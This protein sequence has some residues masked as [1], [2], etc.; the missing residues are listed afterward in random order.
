MSAR[1]ERLYH[2]S[3]INDIPTNVAPL[4]FVNRSELP[5]DQSK[6][7]K[8]ACYHGNMRLDQSKDWILTFWMT[9]FAYVSCLL[10]WLSSSAQ[11]LYEMWS[12]DYSS[13]GMLIAALHDNRYR[14]IIRCRCMIKNNWTIGRIIKTLIKFVMF[15]LVAWLVWRPLDPP[16]YMKLS[17]TV[18]MLVC[19]SLNGKTCQYSNNKFQK[20]QK[21]FSFAKLN[22]QACKGPHRP[23]AIR[24]HDANFQFSKTNK[25]ANG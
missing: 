11:P 24:Q 13:I 12:L 8:I 10:T 23:D 15:T 1:S 19:K 4:T 3:N 2:A 16:L 5:T 7:K 17:F 21:S 18:S 6:S 14:T 9:D 20:R 25:T 22:S